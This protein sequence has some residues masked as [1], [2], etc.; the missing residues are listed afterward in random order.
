MLT[1]RSIAFHVLSA[2]VAISV[3]TPPAFAAQDA[4]PANTALLKATLGRDWEKADK[5]LAAGDDPKQKNESG[6]TPLMAAAIAGHVPTIK[7][8]LA[9]GAPPET[10]D[11]RGRTAL[12]YA[13]ALH[14]PTAV[15]V[16]LAHLPTLPEA[17]QGGDDLAAAA[18]NA[19]DRELL[20]T[21]LRRLP[22]GL[23]WTPA[24]RIAFAKTLAARDTLLGPLFLAKY[25]GPPAP[26]DQAQPLLAHAIVGGDLEQVRA[27]LDFGAD[28][29][30]VLTQVP[31]TAFRKSISSNY[32]NYYLDSTQGISMLMLAAGL[33]QTD[34]VKLLLDRGANRLAMTRGKAKLLALY[35]AAW[36]DCPESIQLLIPQA[37]SK[38]DVRIEVSIDD[39]RARYYRDGKL[40]LTATVSTGRSKFPTRPGEYIVTDK[41]REHR[42]TIYHEASMPFFM[43]LSCRDFGLHQGVVSSSFASHGCIRLPGDV[44][45][46]L[47][48]EV[49]VGTWVSVRR[50]SSTTASAETPHKRATGSIR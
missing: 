21:I 18:I 50:G 30:T 48:K 38:D 44:A 4:A 27:L 9:N 17:A 8:L 43:R 46:R 13:V 31:D 14:Q 28:P 39:Q 47:F 2:L 19:G 26:S 35:F 34:C 23:T 40:V 1:P 10:V 29:N 24:A 22:G 32:V 6:L 12:G 42:S 16:L 33:K 11:A 15:E 3:A 49:P 36:A 7:A 20:D 37:P 41:H 5:L 45:L 25:A